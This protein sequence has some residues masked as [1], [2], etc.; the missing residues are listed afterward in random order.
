MGNS[1]KLYKQRSAAR[2]GRDLNPSLRR[3]EQH[4]VRHFR[5]EPV[6]VIAMGKKSCCPDRIP[7]LNVIKKIRRLFIVA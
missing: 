1:Y 7:T 2:L 6:E 5:D 4:E 3:A